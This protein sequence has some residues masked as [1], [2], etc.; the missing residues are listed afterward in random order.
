MTRSITKDLTL[1]MA[2]F[3]VIGAVVVG[4]FWPN[5][6]AGYNMGSVFGYLILLSLIGTVH[7]TFFKKSIAFGVVGI[8]IKYAILIGVIYFVAFYRAQFLIGFVVGTTLMVPGV[9][10]L[11]FRPLTSKLN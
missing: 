9:I 5:N 6:L 8:V 11:G 7:A 4:I 1:K 10:S 3:W 2:I